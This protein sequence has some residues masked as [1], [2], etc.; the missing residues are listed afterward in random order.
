MTQAADR[1]EFLKAFGFSRRDIV[2]MKA[3]G[4]ATTGNSI[5]A[6]LNDLHVSYRVGAVMPQDRRHSGGEDLGERAGRTLLYWPTTGP[7][8]S[9]GRGALVV[10]GR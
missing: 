3:M 10:Q 8:V 6:A 1:K 4:E 2:R 9:A 5:P 7:S